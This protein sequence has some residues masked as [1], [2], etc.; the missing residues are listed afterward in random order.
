MGVQRD[1]IGAILDK[2]QFL[3]KSLEDEKHEET[4]PL[5]PAIANFY[6]C[7]YLPDKIAE[8]LLLDLEYV[9][10]LLETETVKLVIDDARHDL[11]SADSRQEFK[12]LSP[13]AARLINQIMESA[14][15]RG[16]TKLQ[17]AIYALDR[18]HGKPVQQTEIGG[19]LIKDFIQLL[20]AEKRGAIDNS[21]KPV[22]NIENN[23]EL[24]PAPAVEELSDVDA[25]FQKK[26]E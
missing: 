21:A 10:I 12:A 23:Q 20:D 15:E 8:L 6:A 7:G 9:K 11:F 19:S 25:W 14:T 17:A 13:R 24:F 26:G 22:K 16:A 3:I 5:G 2:G 4:H 18:A 1:D